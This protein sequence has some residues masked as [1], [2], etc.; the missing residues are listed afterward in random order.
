MFLEPSGADPTLTVA[1]EVVRGALV[2]SVIRAHYARTTDDAP[3]QLRDMRLKKDEL[4]TI[5][6]AHGHPASYVVASEGAQKPLDVTAMENGLPLRGRF[7][8]R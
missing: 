8:I 6:R 1:P 2:D 4:K 3:E 7:S 5:M